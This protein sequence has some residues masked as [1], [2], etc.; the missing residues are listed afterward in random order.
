MKSTWLVAITCSAA[1]GCLGNDLTIDPPPGDPPPGGGA[2]AGPVVE[3]AEADKSEYYAD[4]D[5]D[6]YGDPNASVL[7]CE[8]PG[9]HVDNDGDCN[10][11]EPRTHSGAIELCGDSIDNDCDGADPCVLNLTAH[12][13]FDDVAGPEVMDMSGNGLVGILQGGLI[14]IPDSMLTFDGVDDYVE[15]LGDAELFQLPVGTVTF[16]FKPAVIGPR[17]SMVSKDSS[18]NDAGGHLSFYLEGNGT[19]RVRLQS[20]NANYEIQSLEPLA[21]NAWHQ[22]TFLFGGNE[23]MTLYVNGIEA[24]KDPYTGGLIRNREPLAI[25]AGTDQSGDLTAQPISN[26]FQGQIADVQIYD[27]Q[28]LPTELTGLRT[29]TTP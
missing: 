22:V 28:L 10:D 14:N 29:A 24:G 2:D 5:G 4:N 20:N 13:A 6:G 17:M 7:A 8:A 3:C 12:W 16:W 23:G 9:G 18:G 26:P 15:V 27:R 1:F 25:G 19:V 11:L 21:P